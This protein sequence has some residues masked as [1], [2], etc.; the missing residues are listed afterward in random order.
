MLN[1]IKRNELKIRK[2]S[3]IRMMMPM[4]FPERASKRPNYAINHVL[5]IQSHIRLSHLSID[6]PVIMRQSSSSRC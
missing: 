5:N 2:S 1:A 3:I 4:I 6:P